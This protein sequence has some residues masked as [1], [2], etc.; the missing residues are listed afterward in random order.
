MAI[1][2]LSRVRR[3]VCAL[4]LALLALSWGYFVF[5]F[6]RDYRTIE[7]QSSNNLQTL[8]TG[9]AAHVRQM[10]RVSDVLLLD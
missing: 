3:N 5:S 6:A 1:R 8:A 9:F 2:P 4:L 7:Q 10:L